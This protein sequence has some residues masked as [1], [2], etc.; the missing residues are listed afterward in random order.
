MAPS[1]LRESVSKCI[2][3]GS[4]DLCSFYWK[5]LPLC[6]SARL[7]SPPAV[8]PFPSFP[9][10]ENMK[11][12]QSRARILFRW[13]RSVMKSENWMAALGCSRSSEALSLQRDFLIK[14]Q[15]KAALLKLSSLSLNA[16]LSDWLL[17]TKSF[18]FLIKRD[19][20][21]RGPGLW[22]LTIPKLRGSRAGQSS[23]TSS[24]LRPNPWPLSVTSTQ[25]LLEPCPSSNSAFNFGLR[26]INVFMDI[27][28]K[29]IQW[30]DSNYR[31]PFVSLVSL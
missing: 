20:E 11:K 30:C 26:P 6:L 5:F 13:M 16:T 10:W 24:C 21:F 9:P 2:W 1:C 25:C 14:H 17:L 15:F 12:V 7:G 8:F 31:R 3:W 18:F 27:K 29:K 19:I 22:L 4:C 28:K 23:C